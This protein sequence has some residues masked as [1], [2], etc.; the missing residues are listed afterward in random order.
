MG[1]RILKEKSKADRMKKR[2][3]SKENKVLST[4]NRESEKVKRKS[5]SIFINDW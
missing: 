4:D 3:E 2:K 1:I 5:V